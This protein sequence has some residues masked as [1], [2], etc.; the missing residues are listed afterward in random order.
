MFKRQ[1][2]RRNIA[3]RKFNGVYECF[4][5]WYDSETGEIVR[6]RYNHD[7]DTEIEFSRGRLK[8]KPLDIVPVFPEVIEKN[9][10]YINGVPSSGGRISLKTGGKPTLYISK[11]LVDFLYCSTNQPYRSCYS[12][13]RGVQTD[14]KRMW[15]SP[16][17]YIAYL[18]QEEMPNE[19]LAG[20]S[21]CPDDKTVPKMQGRAFV[22]TDGSHFLVGRPYGKYGF[23]V[24]DALRR[25]FPNGL[26]EFQVDIF[27]QKIV[28]FERDNINPTY[29]STS[30]NFVHDLLDGC[31]NKKALY[32]K[33][34]ICL[35]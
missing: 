27:N 4:L 1:N 8:T 22:Y 9:A 20:K 15:E 18:S 23:E 26:E 31:F 11:R 25:F 30:V 12:L 7:Y 5:R 29:G 24:R 3:M 10:F 34:K 6:T 2:N 33:G 13:D 16:Y 21:M 17:I 35:N 19:T 14:L 32:E 28:D